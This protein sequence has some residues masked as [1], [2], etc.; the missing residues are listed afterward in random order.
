MTPIIGKRYQCEVCENYDL[1]EACVDMHP[2][3]HPFL[4]LRTPHAYH[5]HRGYTIQQTKT[6]SFYLDFIKGFREREMEKEEDQ[7]WQDLFTHLTRDGLMHL[8]THAALREV[9]I[10]KCYD[11]LRYSKT[12]M[13]LRNRVIEL[14]NLLYVDTRDKNTGTMESAEQK[15]CHQ[16]EE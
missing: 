8:R 3:D 11:A 6:I 14:L 15:P 9:T 4:L 13:A 12:S 10:G 2:A 7:A 16:M 5:E 1:C